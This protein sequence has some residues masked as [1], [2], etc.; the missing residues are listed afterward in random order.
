MCLPLILALV[1][2]SIA[3]GAGV[4]AV[5]YY[6][7]FFIVSTILQSVG[8]GLLT[9][10]TV[11]VSSSKWIGYQILYGFGVGLAMQQP[12]IAVQTVLPI[13]DV[14]VGTAVIMFTQTFGGA[15]FV[16]VAQNVFTNR[17]LAGLMEVAQGFDANLILKLGATSLTEAV[18]E[19][20]LPGVLVAYNRAL[21]QTWYVSVAMACLTA[22]GTAGLEWK[23]VKGKKIEMGAGA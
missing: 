20:F 14:P 21:T 8:A 1:I 3:G 16:S 10:F 17:L 12:L 11:D 9:T 5:G 19:Q 4:T 6:V 18:P 13:A 2:M 15:L 22:L 7:P 23:S